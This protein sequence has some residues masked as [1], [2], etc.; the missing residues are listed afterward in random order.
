MKKQQA[1]LF[2]C[3]AAFGAVCLMLYDVFRA[4]RKEIRHGT[5]LIILEDT[6]FSAGVCAGCYGIFFYKNYGALRAYGFLGMMMGAM[7][8]HLT[9]RKWVYRFLEIWFRMIFFPFRWIRR[10]C[11]LWKS[12]RKALTKQE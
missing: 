10:K 1:E 8:Y 6:L 12:H 3:F 9:L 4:M 11:K 2:L 5:I 7:L